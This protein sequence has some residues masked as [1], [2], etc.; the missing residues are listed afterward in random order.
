MNHTQVQLASGT[1]KHWHTLYAK[2][3]YG[4]HNV[5]PVLFQCLD[6]LVP[7]DTCLSHNQ[8]DILRFQTGVIHLFPVVL[9]L[10]LLRIPRLN[11]LTLSAVMWVIVTGVGI[12]ITSMIIVGGSNAFQSIVADLR[13]EILDFGFTEDTVMVSLAIVEWTE[14]RRR[15]HTSKYCLKG[16]YR[17]PV[18]WWRKGSILQRVS[19]CFP[20]RTHA[21][22]QNESVLLLGC[23]Q[24]P[25][26]YN[27]RF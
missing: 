16:I 21:Q 27:S 9:V 17:H 7:R 5:V 4:I 12:A 1:C 14:W 22:Q 15:K 6:S 20:P 24:T 13:T 3:H 10:I 25:P 19:L 2:R 18:G 8:L 26:D 23:G 11:G